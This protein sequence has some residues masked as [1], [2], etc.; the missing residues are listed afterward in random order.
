MTTPSRQELRDW[1]T[2]LTLLYLNP[3]DPAETRYVR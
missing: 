2:A 3:A 1:S